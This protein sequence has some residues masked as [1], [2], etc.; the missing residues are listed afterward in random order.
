MLQSPMN[1][2]L[3]FSC[4]RSLFDSERPITTWTLINLPTG[5]NYPS[6][7]PIPC[8]SDMNDGS[9]LIYNDS[10]MNQYNSITNQRISL[11]IKTSVGIKSQE[12]NGCRDNTIFKIL[13]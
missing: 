2:L 12:P 6:S 8:Q 11:D 7:F 13:Y 1:V 9:Y 5:S 3:E 10:L 4:N